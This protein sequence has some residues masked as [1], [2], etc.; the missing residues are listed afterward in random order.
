VKDALHDLW[1]LGALFGALLVVA[2]LVNRFQPARRGRV[3]RA[4]I[5]LLLAAL[6][7]S[8]AWLLAATGS[9][10]WSWRLDF[11]GELFAAMTL[12]NLVCL[13]LF[14][15]VLPG[16]SAELPAI[17][18]DLV[19]GAGYIA[20]TI[21]V[22]RGRGVQLGDVLATSAVVS[23]VLALSLQSTLGNVI[24]GV[25]LQLDGSIRAGDWIQLENGRT[26]KVRQVSWRHTLVETRDWGTIVVPNSM[27]LAQQILVLGKREGAPLQHRYWI[28]FSVDFSVPPSKVIRVVDEALQG[29]PIPNV[30]SDPKPHCLCMDFASPGRE[31]YAYYAVRYWLTDLAHD[32]GTSSRVRERIHAALARAQIS[33]ARPVQTT[34][35]VPGGERAAARAVER[36]REERLRAL[37]SLD[38]FKSLKGDEL[39]WVA[40]HLVPAPFARG[41]IITRKG[42]VA[43]WLYIV[44]AGTVEVRLPAEEGKPSRLLRT[45]EAPAF[46]GE[47]GLLT[48]EPRS[49]DVIA[50]SDVECL[51]LDKPGFEKII[52][53]RPEI[54]KAMSETM[55]HNRVELLAALEQIAD[56]GA[57]SVHEARMAAEILRK[58]QSFFGL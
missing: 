9:T 42:A 15:V 28:Y 32:D 41:E 30:A 46:F 49:A 38:L 18:S 52:K 23:A 57:R 12:V 17:A 27:L 45:L 54:A 22:L 39:A 40:D 4:L 48:G 50:A 6:C 55:A 8:V 14:D 31:G 51:R 58:I 37:Q 16:A 33:F 7:S 53:E 5:L 13:A 44:V 2:F 29:A 10:V 26:G 19:T 47:M 35:F 3:R 36:Q 11:A 43:H 21:I 20:A 1:Q 25:A 56:Q 24:G 34:T